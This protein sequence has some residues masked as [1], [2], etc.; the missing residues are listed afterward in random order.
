MNKLAELIRSLPASDVQLIKQDLE[1]GNL[2]RVITERLAELEM[3]QKVCPT[4]GS[5]LADDAPYV[6]FFG[7]AVRK[8]ARFDALDCLEFFIDDLKETEK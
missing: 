2:G 6:L 1:E 7:K 4:C 8:K 5:P 3:P